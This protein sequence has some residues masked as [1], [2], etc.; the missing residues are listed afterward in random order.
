MAPAP[1]GGRCLHLDFGEHLRKICSDGIN[2]GFSSRQVEAI[3][4]VMNGQLLD[5]SMFWVAQTVVEWFL[6][7][8]QFD[9][10]RDL[11]VL[12]GLPRHVGQARDLASMGVD[13]RLVAHLDCA[14]QTAWQRKQ[15]SERNQGFED[16]TTRPDS[17]Y[18]TF[19]RKLTSFE[20]DT[21][22]VLAWYTDRNVPV[23]RVPVA[24]DSSPEEMLSRLAPHLPRVMRPAPVTLRQTA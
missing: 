3:R 18:D 8:H 16:R 22:P 20:A 12:N 10:K 14:V 23:V 1:G 2:P 19:V 11:L 15:L 5:D 6:R 4:S 13:V 24:V 9:T 7:S 21:V 17:D